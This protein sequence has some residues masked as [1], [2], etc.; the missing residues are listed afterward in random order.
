MPTLLPVLSFQTFGVKLQAPCR[1]IL[2]NGSIPLGSNLVQKFPSRWTTTL[3]NKALWLDYSSHVMS[4]SQSECIIYF[5][6]GRVVTWNWNIF[7]R[8]PLG[9][10]VRLRLETPYCPLI[11]G[12]TWMSPTFLQW[13]VRTQNL[14][15][16]LSE[17]L[18]SCLK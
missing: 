16:C 2:D 7:S 4:F 14:Q 11:F 3:S 13:W 5:R 1:Q 15:L 12:P 18:D 8:L 17:S 10:Q 6:L 9:S